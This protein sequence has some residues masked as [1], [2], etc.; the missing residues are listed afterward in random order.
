[1]KTAFFEHLEDAAIR[2][3]EEETGIKIFDPKVICVTNNLRTFKTERLHY[4]SVILLVTDFSG[5]PNIMEP[6]K[7][8]SWEWIDPNELPQ[9]H[10]D[11]SEYAVQCFLEGKF[12]IKPID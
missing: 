7:C 2:E 12:Y 8:E 5:E 6:D 11:A 1:M 9:P 4:V 10:F 3:V